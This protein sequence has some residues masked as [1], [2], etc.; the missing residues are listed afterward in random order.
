[1]NL[2][3]ILILVTVLVSLFSYLSSNAEKKRRIEEAAARAEAARLAREEKMRKAG[4]STSGPPPTFKSLARQPKMKTTSPLSTR[5]NDI[6]NKI[7]DD[8]TFDHIESIELWGNT[9]PGELTR[10]KGKDAK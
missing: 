1:M 6:I 8:S 10:L 3:V 2:Y 4:Q 9:E 5:Q 7:I